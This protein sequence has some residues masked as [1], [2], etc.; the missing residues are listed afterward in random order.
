MKQLHGQTIDEELKLNNISLHEE[1]GG[2]DSGSVSDEFDGATPS[3][4]LKT[5]SPQPSNRQ[6]KK[7]QHATFPSE[8]ALTPMERVVHAVETALEMLDE[9]E[10]RKNQ[11]GAR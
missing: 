3:V 1:N 11:H 8:V 2:D 5:K 10:E 9:L 4:Q 6:E 7:K